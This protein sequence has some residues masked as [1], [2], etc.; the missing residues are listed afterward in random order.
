VPAKHRAGGATATEPYQYQPSGAPRRASVTQFGTTPRRAAKRRRTRAP[1]PVAGPLTGAGWVALAFSLTVALVTHGYNLFRYPLY[2]TDEGIYTEQAWSVLNEGKLSPYT[3]FYDH[4]PG[5]WLTLAGWV[6]MLPNHFETFGN[7]INAGRVLMVIA[8]LASVF[9]L[10]EVVRRYS[11]SVGAASLAGFAFSVS[12]L[13]VY[14]QR[15]VLLDNMM[16]FWV[17]LGLYLLAR[18][19]GRVVTVMGAGTALGIAMVTKENAAFLLPGFAYLMHRSLA[20]QTNRRFGTT[21]WWFAA[22]T[23]PSIYMLYA[24]LKNELLPQGMDFNLNTPP[25]NHVSLLYTVWWQW[26]RTTGASQGSVF[27]DLLRS[28]WLPKDRFLLVAGAVATG[29]ILLMYLQDRRRGTALLGC[30]LLAIGYGFYLARSVLLDFYVTPLI[31]LLS[32]NIGLF[33]GRLTRSMQSVGTAALTMVLVVPPL[34]LPG[35]YLIKYNDARTH[36][37]FAD[38]YRLAL[39]S[40]QARQVDWIRANISPDAYMI[41]DDDIWVALH[42]ERPAYRNAHSHWK[43]SSDPDVRDK[44]FHSDWRQLSYVV[45]SN[46]MRH[47][48]KENNGGGQEN[49]ILQAIDQHG[50][51]VWQLSKGNVELSIVQIGTG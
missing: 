35:G 36:L 31:P 26:N 47:A 13:A 3:Y 17:L 44:I 43:A 27:A 8:Q 18:G 40:M 29:G 6:G 19:G 15:Q 37:Q 50:R 24:T 32:L 12:P 25:A 34:A 5:G 51:Q 9:F 4:A 11:G 7:P 20:G 48:M 1:L 46:K 22:L 23:P 39:T 14:Y 16:V 41:I 38:Q 30:A 28:S 42:D 49:W 2:L 33:W 21:F 10:F 45:M